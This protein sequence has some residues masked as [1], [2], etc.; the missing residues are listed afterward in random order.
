M[1]GFGLLHSTQVG[2]QFTLKVNGSKDRHYTVVSVQEVSPYAIP[3]DT[4]N[5]KP[6]LEL[7]TCVKVAYSP[8]ESMQYPRLLV[9]ATENEN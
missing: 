7:Y 3:L 9:I 6:T 1:I 2:Y 8:E 5:D 4:T